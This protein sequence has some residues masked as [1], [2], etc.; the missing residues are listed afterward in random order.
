MLTTGLSTKGQLILPKKIRT[1]RA[2][3]PGTEFNIEATADGILLRP[4]R[5]FPAT[6][7]DEVAG[8][9][10]A[11]GKPKTLSRMDAAIGRQVSRRHDSGRY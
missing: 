9:L 3:Q 5:P 11:R 2:W 7:L 1:A 10:R 8:C 6:R 4:A